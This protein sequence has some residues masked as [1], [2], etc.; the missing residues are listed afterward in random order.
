MLTETEQQKKVDKDTSVSLST[1]KMDVT[2]DAVYPG[3]SPDD[4]MASETPC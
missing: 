4:T 3:L 2:K 1:G